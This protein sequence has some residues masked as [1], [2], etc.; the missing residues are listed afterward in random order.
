MLPIS[1]TGI[2][3]VEAVPS[4]STCI[5]V[6]LTEMYPIKFAN[7][8]MIALLIYLYTVVHP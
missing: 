3:R 5:M 1:P 8:I 7:E 2:A 4:A 6:V